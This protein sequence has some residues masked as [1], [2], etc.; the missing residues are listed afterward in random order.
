MNYLSY[1]K[2]FSHSFQEQRNTHLKNRSIKTMR[3]TH[4]IFKLKY[5]EK[6]G[7]AHTSSEKKLKSM[8]LNVILVPLSSPVKDYKLSP[9][10]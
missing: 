1:G 8:S 5:H 4:A 6:I 10:N 3:N 7:K 9:W 2:D